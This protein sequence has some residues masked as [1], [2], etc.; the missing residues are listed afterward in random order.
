MAVKQ[1]THNA[2]GGRRRVTTNS[3]MLT[4]QASWES[5]QQGQ[6]V[7]RTDAQREF[8]IQQMEDGFHLMLLCYNHE[9]VITRLTMLV[10]L[11]HLQQAMQYAVSM[12]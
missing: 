8:V 4:A 12:I 11:P 7:L 1:F 5:P 9:E 2:N 6:W 10:R 3:E